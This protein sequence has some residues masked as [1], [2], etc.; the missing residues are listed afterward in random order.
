MSRRRYLVA[1]DISDSFRLRQVHHTVKGYGYALQYSVF[2][3]DMTD[4]EKIGLRSDLG[5]VIHFSIDRVA[6]VDLGEA[7]SRGMD[8]F[9]FM[10]VSPRLPKVGGPTIV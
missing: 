5:D 2:I 9:E 8:C 1:Y 6:I 3:C 4:V 10:G 7:A